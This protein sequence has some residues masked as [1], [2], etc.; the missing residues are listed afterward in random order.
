MTKKIPWDNIVDFATHPDFCGLMLY[1][2]QQTLLKLIFL[3][4]EAMTDYDLEIIEEWREGFKRPRDRY[5]VQPDI[6]DRIKYL[7]E[8]G[9]RRFPHIQAV[10]GRRASKGLLGAILATE[11]IAY[12]HALDD[13]QHYYGVV[14]NKAGYV[15]VLATSQSQAKRHQFADI[16]GLVS[17]CKYLQP[18][19]SSLKDFELTVRTPA[20]LRHLAELRAAG[21]TPE[22]DIASLRVVALS[23]VSDVVRGAAGIAN[24]Y[25]EA[26]H[27]I[28]TGSTKSGEEI[29]ESGQPALDQFG[30]DGLTYLPSSPFCL[31]PSTRVLTDDLRWV[32]VGDLV[33]GDKVVGFDEH[34]PGGHGNGRSWRQAEVTETSI[35]HAL[36]Y[37]LT[38]ASGKRIVCTGEH[39]WLSKK[40][41]PGTGRGNR[42]GIRVPHTYQWWKTTQLRPGDQIKTLGVDPWSTDET[43]EGG[44]LAGVFDGEGH[45]GTGKTRGLWGFSQNPGPVLDHTMKLL[46]GKGFLFRDHISEYRIHKLYSVGGFPQTLRF[47]GSIRPE[48]L[49]P[50][51][52]DQFYGSRIYSKTS[53]APD[54]VVSVRQVEDG[55][56]VALGTSTNTLVA[57]SLLSHNTK[58]GFFFRLYQ[59]GSVIVTHDGRPH[60]V[61]AEEVDAQGEL[62]RFASEPEMLIVQLPSWGLYLDWERG[63]ELV[64]TR[65]SAGPIQWT[66]DGDRPENE[67]VRRLRQRNP[68]SFKVEREGQFAE[69]LGQYLDSAKVDAM[70][71]PVP[72]RDPPILTPTAFGR[73][74]YTYRIH[75]D[76]SKV[77]A[78]FALAVAHTELAPPDNF[79][80]RW[81]HVIL[82]RLH[83]WQ[84]IDFPVNPDSGRHEVDYLA[85]ERE[86]DQLLYTFPSASKFSADQF[87][88]TGL[89]QRLKI[90]YSPGIRIVEDTATEKANFERAEKFK[91]A[92]NLG[93]VHSF[94]DTFYEDDQSLLE[95]ECKFL[96]EKNGKVFKQDFGPVTTKDLY[97]AVS[98]VVVDLLRDALERWETGRLTA[99]AFGSTNVAGLKSGREIERSAAMGSTYINGRRGSGRRSWDQLDDY[100]LARRRGKAR[101]TEYAASSRLRSIG[102]RERKGMSF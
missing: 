67:R 99:H 20:D 79:G 5:G 36:R 97:D 66:P 62:L 101:D 3:E 10:M 69:V 2:R 68:D 88:S 82:D 21:I 33:V 31:E 30:K 49:L 80:E 44:Y 46:A 55:P 64:A 8:H 41:L 27:F 100:Q 12:F 43:R 81:P 83:V 94:R 58:V 98:V 52:M 96:S 92:V 102:L 29:Y 18:H 1:P 89:L 71:D 39:M 50:K 85:V 53:G 14:A 90:K 22:H 34:N 24:F 75:C 74:D 72:W 13:W 54:V 84:P 65:F 48:R 37:E 59:Q 6:W 16:R 47:M 56:V 61:R 73:F 23:T 26:A 45:I 87:N 63:E 38:M 93:W 86:L 35:I 42:Q 17:T 60:V 15:S 11:H 78:N 70:F 51:V 4:T 9:Y 77:G 40:P 95:M 57:E 32:P 91:S 28:Q 25:D 76:P 7:Q 19:I